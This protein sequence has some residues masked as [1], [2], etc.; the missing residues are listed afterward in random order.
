M[1][2]SLASRYIL[3]DSLSS[4]SEAFASMKRIT[5]S[6][7]T[8]KPTKSAPTFFSSLFSLQ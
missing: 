7:W 2:A 5:M 3:V 1:T 4:A 8:S 6:T